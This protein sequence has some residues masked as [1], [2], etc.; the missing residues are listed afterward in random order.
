MQ[1]IGEMR[2]SKRHYYH[3]TVYGLNLLKFDGQCNVTAVVGFRQ[4]PAAALCEE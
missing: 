4:P 3:K 1:N 2:D